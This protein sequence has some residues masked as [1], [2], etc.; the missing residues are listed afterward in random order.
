MTLPACVATAVKPNGIKIF[1]VDN[2]SI[3]VANEKQIFS[4]GPTNLPRNPPDWS[5]YF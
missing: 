4:N 1:S 2:V 3:F 5:K